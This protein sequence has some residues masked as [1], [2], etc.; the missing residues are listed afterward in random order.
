MQDYHRGLFWQGRT[1]SCDVAD[2]HTTFVYLP[3]QQPERWPELAVLVPWEMPE[4][5]NHLSWQYGL[6]LA[7]AEVSWQSCSRPGVTQLTHRTVFAKIGM[8]IPADDIIPHG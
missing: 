4:T 2:S 5:G 7:G 3:C 8:S 6:S 1:D